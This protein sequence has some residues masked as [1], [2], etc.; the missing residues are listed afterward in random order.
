MHWG[1]KVRRYTLPLLVLVLLTACSS[2]TELKTDLSEKMFG[3]ES[4]D[5]PTEL[6]EIKTM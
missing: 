2:I 1:I 6:K 4:K 5:P 3:K